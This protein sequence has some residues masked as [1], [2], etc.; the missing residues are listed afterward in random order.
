[1][2][3]DLSHTVFDAAFMRGV[4]VICDVL[5]YYVINEW[6]LCADGTTLAGVWNRYLD[7]TWIKQ[8][9]TALW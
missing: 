2:I 9:G 3:G 6:G 7:D 5:E 8:F 4:P 1:M